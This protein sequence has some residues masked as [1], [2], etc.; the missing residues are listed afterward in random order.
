MKS[1]FV[2]LLSLSPICALLGAPAVDFHD[3]IELQLWSL[4]GLMKE[5]VPRALNLTKRLGFTVVET[6]SLAPLTAGQFKAELTARGLSA[7]GM[8]VQYA[9]LQ[10]GLAA[11]IHDA[12][13]IG[14]K[15]IICP[16]V[17]QGPDGFTD[18]LADQTAADFNRWGKACSAAGLKFGYHPHGYEFRVSHENPQELIFDRLMR[19]TRP[20]L[21]CYELDTFW[22]WYAGQDPVKLLEKYPSR[23]TLMHLKD[24][25]KGAPTGLSVGHAPA[26]DNVPLGQG[27]IDWPPLLREAQKLGIEHYIIEDEAVRP[28]DSLPVTLAYLAGLR[29]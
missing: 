21:V 5:S 23:W 6:S 7:L 13:A 8:H 29:L 24:M 26:S 18:A 16:W 27:Q 25:R 10:T 19:Q 17:P 14:A 12:Q 1:L 2:L 3:H 20:E 9:D 4:K 15:Y 11:A 28:L 22:I